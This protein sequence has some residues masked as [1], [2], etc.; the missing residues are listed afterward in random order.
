MFPKTFLRAGPIK[1]AY[2]GG[3]ACVGG[4]A[5]RVHC[6]TVMGCMGAKSSAGGTEG[7][8]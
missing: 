1:K 8:N 2:V 3:V 4:D 7:H 6:G 5:V